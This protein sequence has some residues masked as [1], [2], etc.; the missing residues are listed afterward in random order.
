MS[1][2]AAVLAG[3]QQPG[4]H[5]WHAAFDVADVRYAVEHAGWRFAHV[6]GWTASTKPEVLADLGEALAFPAYY[7]QNLD[8]LADCLADVA[9]DTVLLWDGWGTLAREDE[10]AFRGILAVLTERAQAGRA[11]AGQPG[12]DP[13]ASDGAGVAGRFSVLLRGDGPDLPDAVTSLD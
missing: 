3:Q 5:R 8:A 7:G 6:D 13:T 1:G 4:V 2:L 10:R 12:S 9:A 11:D